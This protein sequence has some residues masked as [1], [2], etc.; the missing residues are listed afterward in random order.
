[1]RLYKEVRKRKLKVSIQRLDMNSLSDFV[2]SW[3]TNNARHKAELKDKAKLRRLK[4]QARHFEPYV[5]KLT[6]SYQLSNRSSVSVLQ[7]FTSAVQQL[8]SP[9]KKV[10][11]STTNIKQKA[12]L[13]PS[14]PPPV[15]KKSNGTNPQCIDLCSSSDDEVELRT[16][17]LMR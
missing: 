17:N 1:M 11:S 3:I 7:S 16:P 12:K 9:E 15:I 14:L 2:K 13:K 8:C 6:S 10:I 5:P 4:E